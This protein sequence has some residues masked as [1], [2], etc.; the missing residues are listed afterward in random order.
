MIVEDLLKT[1]HIEY[2]PS[3]KDFVIRC[4]NPDHEDRHPSMRIDKTT[5]IFNCFSCGFSGNLFNHFGEKGNWLEIKRDK[6]KFLINTKLTETSGI[7]MPIGAEPFNKE[8]RNISRDT[9]NDFEAFQHHS[10]DF[11]GRV[12]FPIRN[13]AGNIVSFCGRHMSGGTPKYLFS[14]TGSKLPL[15]PNIVKPINGKVIIVEGIF[16]MLNLYDKG[17][18]NVICAFGVNK[19]TQEKINIL[20]IQGI[21]GVDIFFDNDTAGQEAST[22]LKEFLEKN[23]I[24]TRNIVFKNT[25]DPGELTASKVIN[26]KEKLYSEY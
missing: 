9:Y 8:W 11:I 26:L 6:L 20:K 15:F 21:T 13:I 23:E 12:V 4:L 5:G 25:K 17:L 22:K 10:P 24:I 3:G 7:S 16:D 19:V 2:L 18:H 14:P 1:K